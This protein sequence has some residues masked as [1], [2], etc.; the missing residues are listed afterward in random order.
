MKEKIYNVLVLV[1]NDL[2][3][4]YLNDNTDLVEDLGLDSLQTVK[5]LT[6]IEE[7]LDIEI[8]F[9]EFDLSLLNNFN[10][11]CEFIELQKTA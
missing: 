3:L 7:K 1:L 2:K 9:E 11:F 4:E 10:S 6:L 5:F 8:D